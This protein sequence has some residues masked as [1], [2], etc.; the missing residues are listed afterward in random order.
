MAKKENKRKA[1]TKGKGIREEK[2]KKKKAA[3]KRKRKHDEDEKPKAEAG[4]KK[5]S[6]ASSTGSVGGKTIYE[7]TTNDDRKRVCG[8]YD[9]MKMVDRATGCN[10]GAVRYALKNKGIVGSAKQYRVRKIE[11][12][13]RPVG[14]TEFG[15]QEGKWK[16]KE[17]ACGL[18]SGSNNSRLGSDL[19]LYLNSSN[20]KI[21]ND[22]EGR[23]FGDVIKGVATK[24]GELL[25]GFV[26]Y[27]GDKFAELMAWKK[28]DIGSKLTRLRKK[29][30]KKKSRRL[31][32][33]VRGTFPQFWYVDGLRPGLDDYTV[34]SLVA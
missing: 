33:G 14:P 16:M 25:N 10:P 15:Q 28:G 11:N 5:T 24:R 31:D 9:S 4:S 13:T 23:T 29:G 3:D 27:D 30:S 32:K 12:C 18:G 34:F 26:V 6:S 20:E 22:T 17:H 1:P 21:P 2:R 8:N 7:V 19:G